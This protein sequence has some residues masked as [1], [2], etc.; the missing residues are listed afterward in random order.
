MAEPYGGARYILVAVDYHSWFT[1]YYTLKS[2]DETFAH[3]SRLLNIGSES[4][5]APSLESFL[6][7]LKTFIFCIALID[8]KDWYI[9]NGLNW[10]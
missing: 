1:F 3:F 6:W 10:F 4:K 9:Y 2:K 8:I 5:S 7:D